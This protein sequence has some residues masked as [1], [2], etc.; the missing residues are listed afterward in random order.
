MPLKQRTTPNLAYTSPRINEQSQVRSRR[1]A[2]ADTSYAV[3]DKGTAPVFGSQDHRI[4]I[5]E[6]CAN[7]CKDDLKLR[8]RFINICGMQLATMSKTKTFAQNYSDELAEKTA[9]LTR[10]KSDIETLSK[11]IA[12]LQ[13]DRGSFSRYSQM[14]KEAH[15]HWQND[16]HDA[17]AECFA[18]KYLL[19]SSC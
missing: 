7:L 13:E 18:G 1:G 15:S 16:D 3:A 11:R 4:L 2:L 19:V 12:D 14:L 6:M 10:A 17:F 8:D 9:E 5:V